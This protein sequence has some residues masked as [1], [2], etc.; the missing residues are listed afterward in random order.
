MMNLAYTAHY[1][2]KRS[3][4][5]FRSARTEEDD[6]MVRS[7]VSTPMQLRIGTDAD[8]LR[9]FASRLGIFSVVGYSFIRHMG[10]KRPSIHLL[11]VFV[12]RIRRMLKTRTGRI[13][14]TTLT[15]C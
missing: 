2:R 6:Q 12:Q 4:V 13:A 9:T 8:R 10:K 11:S 15:A 14:V 1:C 7:V 3:R 5:V